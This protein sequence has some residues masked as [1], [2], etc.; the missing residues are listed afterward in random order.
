[1]CGVRSAR[2]QRREG[3]QERR[4]ERREES[5]GAAGLRQGATP[6]GLPVI[7]KRYVLLIKGEREPL[8]LVAREHKVENGVL[9]LSRAGWEVGRIIE[10]NVEWWIEDLGGA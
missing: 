4:D 8:V 7:D 3:R 6:R 10:A 5:Q 1:M 2:K 9:V